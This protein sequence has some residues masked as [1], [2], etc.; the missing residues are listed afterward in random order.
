MHRPGPRAGGTRPPTWRCPS[1]TPGAPKA[2]D[3]TRLRRSNTQPPPSAS[4]LSGPPLL[5][6]SATASWPQRSSLIG[7]HAQCDCACKNSRGGKVYE[8][9]R[10]YCDHIV[11]VVVDVQYRHEPAISHDIKY[12]I[13]GT[14][15]STRAACCPW[16]TMARPWS[17][18]C[19]LYDIL[20]RELLSNNLDHQP[21]LLPQYHQPA[22]G[23]QHDQYQRSWDSAAAFEEVRPMAAFA[24]TPIVQGFP[25]A[26]RHIE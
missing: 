19:S 26:Q 15:G 13:Y 6:A 25:S 17:C 10:T 4:L 3:S 14:C 5:S 1:P 8:C 9:G 7:P 12:M 11:V 23:C 21:V 16:P 2:N 24:Y 20:Q 18:R 22:L